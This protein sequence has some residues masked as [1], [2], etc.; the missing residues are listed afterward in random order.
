[1][2]SS[3]SQAW[4][5]L[6]HLGSFWWC[7]SRA[8]AIIIFACPGCCCLP[9]LHAATH[10]GSASLPAE[11]TPSRLAWWVEGSCRRSPKLP[12]AHALVGKAESAMTI[13]HV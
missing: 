6:V 11:P 3:N 12:L 8:A 5:G 9:L 1:L 7:M 10:H 4:P 13:I 2:F